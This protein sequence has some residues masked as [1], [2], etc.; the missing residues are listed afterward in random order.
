[1]WILWV[2]F[3]ASVM[4]FF[5]GNLSRKIVVDVEMLGCPVEN[6]M[7]TNVFYFNFIASY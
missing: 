1:M 5:L 7:T 3:L 6:V 2:K 4:I